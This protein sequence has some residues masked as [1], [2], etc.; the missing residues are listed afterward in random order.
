MRMYRLRAL[1]SAYNE[2]SRNANPEPSGCAWLPGRVRIAAMKGRKG[3]F[4]W[5]EARPGESRED[6]IPVPASAHNFAVAA[7]TQ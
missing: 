7:G 4:V 5:L 1:C 3:I 2:G 6:Q